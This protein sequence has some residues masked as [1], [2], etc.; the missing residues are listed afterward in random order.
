MARRG[1]RQ[2]K[3]RFRAI[4][5]DVRGLN[6]NFDEML[7]FALSRT[8]RDLR[9]EFKTFARNFNTHYPEFYTRM[10]FGRPPDS[11]TGLVSGRAIKVRG[12]AMQGRPNGTATYVM[13]YTD[14]EPVFYYLEAGARRYRKMS[15]DWMSMT[16][17]G[18][19]MKIHPR[20]GR[21]TGWFLTPRRIEP[22]WFSADAVERIAPKFFKRIWRLF[23]YDAVTNFFGQTRYSKPDYSGPGGFATGI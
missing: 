3:M 1:V 12:F 5:T 21:A 18:K 23:G 4:T 15:A 10:G 20:A 14:N 8:A 13:V 11:G 16:M 6:E 2:P 9:I 7:A 22:R 19:G 17:P